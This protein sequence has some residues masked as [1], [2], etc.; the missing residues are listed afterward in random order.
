MLNRRC[1]ESPSQ[2]RGTDVHV[3]TLDMAIRLYAPVAL[4]L[5]ICFSSSIR[6]IT[7][8]MSTARAH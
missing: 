6:Q 7:Q 1:S 8:V 3:F 2:V 4:V 5:Y